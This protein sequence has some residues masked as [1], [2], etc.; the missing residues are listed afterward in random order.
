MVFGAPFF[1]ALSFYCGNLSIRVGK[2]RAKFPI[3][4]APQSRCRRGA[5]AMALRRNGIALTP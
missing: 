1:Y 5:M 3:A 4:L 2:R